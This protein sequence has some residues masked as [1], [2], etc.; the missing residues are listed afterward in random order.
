MT[1]VDQASKYSKQYQDIELSN[2]LQQLRN[3]PV[4]LQQFLQNAQ[5]N[6]YTDVIA[7][8][9]GAFQKI[10][11]DLQRASYCGRE[12]TRWPKNRRARA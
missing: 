1:S 11:G 3:D 8:K 5:T 4:S 2:A 9:D 12:R 10:Y 7:Q 6:L